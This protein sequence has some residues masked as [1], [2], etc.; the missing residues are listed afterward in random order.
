MENYI[1][2]ELDKRYEEFKADLDSKRT[3]ADIDLV[4]QAYLP[5]DTKTRP[6]NLD[7]EFRA[8][9]ISQIRLFV[10]VSHDSISST[11]CY[12]LYLLVTHPIALAQIRVEHDKL[13]GRD[14][15]AASRSAQL[16]RH[17][18]RHALSDTYRLHM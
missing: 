1:E 11:I 12:I 16:K 13:L 14:L 2:H 8:F 6:E 7:P 3:K 5:N 10:F 9:A 18:T 17:S 4:L 15:S